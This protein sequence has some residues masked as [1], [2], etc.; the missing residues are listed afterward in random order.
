MKKKVLAMMLA[1][2][3]VMAACGTSASNDIADSTETATE[4][5]VNT[6]A[7]AGGAPAVVE[8]TEIPAEPKTEATTEAVE[9]T[10]IAEEATEAE[11]DFAVVV[12]SAT[13]YAKSTVNVRKGPS[14][15]YEKV[16][17]LSTNQE[18]K[19][20]GQAE[21]GWYQIELDGEIVYVSNNYLVDEMVKVEAPV[22]TSGTESSDNDGTVASGNTTPSAPAVGGSDN[23]NADDGWIAD[24][25]P[26]FEIGG[27]FDD[28]TDGYGPGVEIEI[29]PTP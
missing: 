1:V 19:V 24:D 23:Y 16:G 26:S 22:N 15:D 28:C 5:G 14:A 8:P 29:T 13:K 20:I 12:M 9:T 11:A 2:T 6:E 27:S 7:V 3:L 18:V 17:S 25:E 21:T 4:A 10:E